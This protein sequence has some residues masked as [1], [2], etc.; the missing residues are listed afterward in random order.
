MSFSSGHDSQNILKQYNHRCCPP[1][2]IKSGP[3]N[4]PEQDAVQSP[5]EPKSW[6]EAAGRKKLE[7]ELSF[8][9]SCLKVL[10]EGFINLYLFFFRVRCLLFD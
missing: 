6:E 4:L 5:S 3:V 9:M 1:N 7:D 2:K 10:L 8:L